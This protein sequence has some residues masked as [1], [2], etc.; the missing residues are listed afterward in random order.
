MVEVSVVLNFVTRPDK[1]PF[2]FFLQ[3]CIQ[4][5]RDRKIHEISYNILKAIN[6]C[7]PMSHLCI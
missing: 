6:E 2:E 5:N 3:A 7:V 4:S 1:I